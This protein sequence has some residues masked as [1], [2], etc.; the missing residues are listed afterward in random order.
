[1]VRRGQQGKRAVQRAQ[2]K[3]SELLDSSEQGAYQTPDR[4]ECIPQQWEIAYDDANTVR[5]QFFLWREGG[6]IAEFVVNVQV[7]AS[8][9]WDTVEYFDCCHGHC[10]LHATN[11]TDVRTIMRLDGIDDVERAFR[12]VDAESHNRARIMR[13]E[14]A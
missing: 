9:G 2:R 8:E 12:Q 3:V 4:G 5:L 13:G 7:L 10:H 11:D 1:V 14:G 6:R